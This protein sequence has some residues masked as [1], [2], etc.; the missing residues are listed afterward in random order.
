VPRNLPSPPA[1]W[2]T[3][4]ELLQLLLG[5]IFGLLVLGLPVGMAVT[6]P[7]VNGSSTL[8]ALAVSGVAIGFAFRD[9]LQNY[10]AGILLLWR[11]PFRIGDQIITSSNFEGT[12]DPQL[13]PVY[14]HR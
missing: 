2:G 5:V 1:R 9:I 14:R 7:M 10:F 13:E 12:G 8:S 4:I 11:E 6:F 3:S